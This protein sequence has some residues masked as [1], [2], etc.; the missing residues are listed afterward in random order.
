M[1]QAFK[2]LESKFSTGPFARDTTN[3]MFWN[4]LTPLERKA[5]ANFVEDFALIAVQQ[6]IDA[7]KNRVDELQLEVDKARV[8]P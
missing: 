3:T 6:A 7:M 4:V 1:S 2:A 5:L 8:Q